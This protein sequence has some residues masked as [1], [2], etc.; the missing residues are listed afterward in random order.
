MVCQN[1]LVNADY[2]FSDKQRLLRI[3]YCLSLFCCF[4]YRYPCQQNAIVHIKG[5]DV[6]V[7]KCIPGSFLRKGGPWGEAMSVLAWIIEQRYG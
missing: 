3:D 5:L 6:K 4:K 7:G 2:T 1:F